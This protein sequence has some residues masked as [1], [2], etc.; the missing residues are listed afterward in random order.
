MIAE[1]GTLGKSPD[2]KNS[3]MDD[4]IHK[5]KPEYSVKQKRQINFALF[6]LIPMEK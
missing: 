6:V 3:C 2:F 5:L 4:G 1:L